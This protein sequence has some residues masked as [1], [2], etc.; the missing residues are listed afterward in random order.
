MTSVLITTLNL[1]AVY[2]LVARNT[3]SPQA[4]AQRLERLRQGLASGGPAN[5]VQ[6]LRRSAK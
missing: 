3:G 1:S 5:A 6:D 2:A 4:V